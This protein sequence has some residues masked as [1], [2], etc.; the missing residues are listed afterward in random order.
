MQLPR[1][2]T[3]LKNTPFWTEHYPRPGDLPVSPVPN[4]VDV[5]VVG[6][7]YTGLN[8]ARHL[9]RVGTTVAVLEKNRLGKG[10]SG[11][12]AGIASSG[13]RQSMQVIFQR[14][15][16]ALA[17]ELWQASLDAVDR[18]AEI[19]ADEDVACDFRRNGHMTLAV[20]PA[21]LEKMRKKAAWY[22]HRLDYP[23]H[24]VAGADLRAEVGSAVYCGGLVDPWSASLHPAKYLFGLAT[25]VA[26]Y[27]VYLCEE[28]AVYR[29]QKTAKGWH[30]H[31]SQGLI[32][33]KAVLLATNGTS[34]SLL[35]GL[36]QRVYSVGS[37]SIVTEPLP[38]A[39]RGQISPHGRTFFDSMRQQHYFRLTPDGRLLFGGQHNLSPTFDLQESAQRLQ[40]HLQAIFPNL[41]HVPVTHSWNGRLGQTFDLLPH[42]GQ[43]DGVYYAAGYSGHGLALATYLGIEVAKLMCGHITRSPFS[44][45]PHP[46]R[47]YYRRHAW[48]LP[49][50][51]WYDRLLD[52]F[53]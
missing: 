19:V 22:Q 39:L 15:G 2:H 32:K 44:D 21:H 1:L 4:E 33:A 18:L 42:I 52:R 8:A 26:N 27:G 36:R 20:K 47:F 29:L 40:L 25:A 9:A 46:T 16:A 48:F 31:T 5:V 17:R 50:L 43:I 11:V 13:S 30:V 37:Y 12:N 38:T 14:Y 34:G 23:L 24:L 6:G 45:I 49:I 35:P 7:G 28:T 41:R 51:A 3:E 53:S 10:A